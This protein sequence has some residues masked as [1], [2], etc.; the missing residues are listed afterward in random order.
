VV[1]IFELYVVQI[2]G[3]NLGRHGLMK[4]RRTLGPEWI[5]VSSLC[6]GTTRS[7]SFLDI[8]DPNPFNLEYDR[9]KPGPVDSAQFPALIGT[10][11]SHVNG[12]LQSTNWQRHHVV[13]VLLFGSAKINWRHT[14]S[15]VNSLT[16][17]YF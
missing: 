1:V 4:A 10:V 2:Y 12:M 17:S 16:I 14:N 6:A 13:A 7:E 3:P 8:L 9:L 11:S 5:T 15:L